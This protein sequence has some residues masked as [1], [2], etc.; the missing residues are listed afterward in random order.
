MESVVYD[1]RMATPTSI[2]SIQEWQW[3]IA[4]PFPTEV[5]LEGLSS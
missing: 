4:G 5:S 1:Y 2:A 3:N